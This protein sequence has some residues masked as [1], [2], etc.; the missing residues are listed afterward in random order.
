MTLGRRLGPLSGFGSRVV[1]VVGVVGWCRGL[2]GH[3]RA[4]PDRLEAV[5]ESLPEVGQAG[6]LG[7]ITANDVGAGWPCRRAHRSAARPRSTITGSVASIVSCLSVTR[8][9]ISAPA[10]FLGLL[11]AGAGD[12][13]GAEGR[14]GLVQVNAESREGPGRGGIGVAQGGEQQMVRADRL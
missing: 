6:A 8:I 5:V 14:F 2:R 7:E 13:G 1:G 9:S 12:V 3:R 10:Y 11:V 4:P